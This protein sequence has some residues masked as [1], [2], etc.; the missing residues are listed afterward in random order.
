MNTTNCADCGASILETIN[1]EG[2]V[3]AVDKNSFQFRMSVWMEQD[4]MRSRRSR[5][6]VAHDKTCLPKK[7][8]AR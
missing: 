6:Y 3:I 7:R 5:T 4:E 1:D 8:S 2:E